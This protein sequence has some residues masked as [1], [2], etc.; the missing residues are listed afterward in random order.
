MINLLP[1]AYRQ[2]LIKAYRVRLVVV[3][4]FFIAG[5]LATGALL[6]APSYATVLMQLQDLKAQRAGQQAQAVADTTDLAT[7]LAQS[8]QNIELLRAKYARVPVTDVIS[9]LI[10]IK[11]AGIMLL[12]VRYDRTDA[13]AE[14]LVFSGRSL[15]RDALVS[16]QDRLQDEP[17]IANVTLPISDLAN[18]TDIDF[19][20]TVQLRTSS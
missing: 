10:G 3:A 16:F 9:A 12:S 18:N 20:I 8:D 11:P 5:A 1:T 19:T 2:D 13:G 17:H 4:L 14:T 7:V 15:S 6:V